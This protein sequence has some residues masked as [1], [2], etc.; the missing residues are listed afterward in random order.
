MNVV[1]LHPCLRSRFV[2]EGLI[3]YYTEWMPEWLAAAV[4]R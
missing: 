1:L 3:R 4:R 2:D